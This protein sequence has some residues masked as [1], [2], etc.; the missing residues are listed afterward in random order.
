MDEE[1]IEAEREANRV[2]VAAR[3]K[4]KAAAAAVLAGRCRLTPG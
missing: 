1:Q 3:M 2:E 4:A